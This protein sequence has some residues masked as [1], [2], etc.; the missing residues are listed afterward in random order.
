MNWL[1]GK[2]VLKFIEIDIKKHHKEVVEFRRDSFRVSFGETTNFEEADYLSWLEEK[3]AEFPAGFVLI[4]EDEKYIG[5]LELSIREYE[6]KNIGYVH[7]YYLIPE[8]RGF[9]IGKELQNYAIQ[10]F[11]KN[12]INEYHLRVSPTN[13]GAIRFY[14]KV[15]MEEAGSEVA[16]RVIRMRG[17]L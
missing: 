3:I 17:Y 13:T 4:E 14:R 11:E 8:K 1:G 15:G 7:L 12:K 6:R 9:G 10:F 16:G 2:A 5:Q